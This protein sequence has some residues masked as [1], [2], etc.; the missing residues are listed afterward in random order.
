[1]TRLN[2]DPES[3][4]E[5]SSGL[6]GN[7]RYKKIAASSGSQAG[8]AY[9]GAMESVFAIV[10]AAGAGYWADSHFE[11]SPRWLVVGAIVGF[12]AFVLRLARMARLIEDPKDRPDESLGESEP[13]ENEDR[14]D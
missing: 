5:G 13:D 8:R 1:V 2:G 11:T 12:A 10:I 9:Q 3:G 14:R 6:P 7:R 4:S